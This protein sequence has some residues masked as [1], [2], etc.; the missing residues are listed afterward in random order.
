[1]LSHKCFDSMVTPVRATAR[2]FECDATSKRNELFG[3]LHKA[4]PE[5]AKCLSVLCDLRCGCAMAM[6]LVQ[7]LPS[8]APSAWKG[9]KQQDKCSW[10]GDCRNGFGEPSGR[11]EVIVNGQPH[12]L[13]SWWSE[14]AD[15]VV[16]IRAEHDSDE[17]RS[18]SNQHCRLCW[19]VLSRR[20]GSANVASRVPGFIFSSTTP[21]PK[22][23]RRHRDHSQR[24]KSARSRHRSLVPLCRL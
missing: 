18:W 21:Q 24:P 14:F 2:P 5:Y 17:P 4:L 8:A 7:V 13:N 12:N 10:C 11:G 15:S 19:G 1:M 9:A 23:R 6:V 22:H 3:N 16:T 20:N